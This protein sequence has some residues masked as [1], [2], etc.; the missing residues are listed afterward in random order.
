MK[1]V[2]V[3]NMLCFSRNDNPYS[4]PCNLIYMFLT[5]KVFNYFNKTHTVVQYL[6]VKRRRCQVNVS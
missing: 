4:K 5:L 2:K 6:F 3:F 1:T